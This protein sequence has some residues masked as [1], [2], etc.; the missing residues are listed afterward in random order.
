MKKALSIFFLFIGFQ[1][2]AQTW[3]DTVL[4][5]DK[6]LNRYTDSTPGAQIAIS[7]GGQVIYSSAK[8]LADL[9]H[10]VPLTVNSVI[11][12]GSV[13]KQFTAACILLLEQQGKLSLNDD[14]RKYVP[15]IPGYGNVIRIKHL[16][17]HTSGLKDWGSIAEIS[18]WP[19]TTKTYTN[20]DAFHFMTL[21]KTLN[22]KPGDEFI[23]SNSN[24]NLMAVI[25]Q[26]VS[27]LSLAEYSRKYIFEPAGMTHT[28]W[29][30]N[31]RRIV[32]NRAIAYSRIGNSYITT[33]P[34]E[35]AYGNGGLITNTQDLLKWNNYYLNGKLGSPSLLEKQT[36]VD[37]LNNGKVNNYAAGLFIDSTNGWPVIAHNGATA[38]YRANLEYYPTTDLSITWISNTSHLGFGNIFEMVRNLLVENIKNPPQ[39]VR[40]GDVTI[41]R[42]TFIPYMGLYKEKVTG[43]ALSL[44]IKADG[45]YSSRN[46]EA[47]LPLSDKQLSVG[48]STVDFISSN[49]KQFKFTNAAGVVSWYDGA[50]SARTDERSLQDYTGKYYSTETETTIEAI[51][52]NGGL[53]F[54]RRTGMET[55]LT[56]SY[57][58]G[59]SFPGGEVYFER[60]K[61]KQ[62][63]Q[64]FISV[65]RARKVQFIRKSN[66]P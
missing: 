9:E 45:I 60:D 33:M 29:R 25:I 35:N 5:I 26:R 39:P 19:R 46:N 38:G 4:Q 31:F 21:Q 7:R 58:D 13:S 40:A 12:V 61:K 27:G 43:S 36:A 23:Y 63:V 22:N 48:R 32:L 30:D 66:I 53:I 47:L 64:F 8:G 50:D 44:F 59:F 16:L 11:E 57:K 3:Q 54:Y 1:I 18:G 17:H 62:P 52:K 37:T 20:E 24:Y 10:K 2:Q 56:P 6:I 14:I 15:E 42:S 41:S 34:N 65:S 49:P 55:V 51:L 28:E